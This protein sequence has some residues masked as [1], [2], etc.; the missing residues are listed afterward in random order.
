M[1]WLRALLLCFIPLTA[2]GQQR[3]Q[4]DGPLVGLALALDGCFL[5]GQSRTTTLPEDCLGMHARP[6][7]QQPGNQ[8][9]AGIERCYYD[10][11]LAW[12]LLLNRYYRQRPRGARGDVLV[13][14]QRAWLRYR[15]QACGYFRAYYEGGSMARIMEAQCMM[16]L[17]ARRTAALR[18][19]RE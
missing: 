9:T 6:C 16:E 5:P 13:E 8:T 19:F 12:D 14:V 17:T 10:E 7:L 2:M 1:L 3:A 18:Y 11:L 15:D 4:N